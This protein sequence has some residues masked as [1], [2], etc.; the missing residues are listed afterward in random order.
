MMGADNVWDR[1][2]QV[3]GVEVPGRGRLYEQEDFQGR[4]CR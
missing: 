2:G 1:L 3:H 4:R